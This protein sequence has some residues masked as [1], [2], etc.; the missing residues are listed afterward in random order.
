MQEH[1]YKK[2]VCLIYCSLVCEPLYAVHGAEMLL[3]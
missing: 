3:I 1:Q 2:I